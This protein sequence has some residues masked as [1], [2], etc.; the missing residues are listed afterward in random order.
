V[1]PGPVSPPTARDLLAR[2]AL[3]LT[4]AQ[5]ARLTDLAERWEREAAPLEAELTTATG[6]FARFARSAEQAGRTSLAEIR[7]QAAEVEALSAT[8][9]A[10]RER[11]GR[12]ALDVLTPSAR[13]EI[14]RTDR[15]RGGSR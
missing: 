1:R 9:R 14:D 10:A 6:A 12:D 7:R 2:E 5:R 15:P 4:A 3:G 8:L 11:H 13:A